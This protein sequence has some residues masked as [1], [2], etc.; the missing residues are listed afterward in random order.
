VL[1][2]IKTRSRDVVGT[3]CAQRR[4]ARVGTTD[5]K[6]HVTRTLVIPPKHPDLLVVS[7]GSNDNFDYDAGNMATGRSCVKVFDTTSIPLHGSR[8]LQL[9]RCLTL[10]K[11]QIV[12]AQYAYIAAAHANAHE[13]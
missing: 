6:G 9:Q 4:Y 5:S 13:H 11:F 2:R 12:V 10:S 3:K 1:W 7:H 8:W